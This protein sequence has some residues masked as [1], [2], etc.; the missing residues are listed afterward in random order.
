MINNLQEQRK[1]TKNGV[2][3]LTNRSN[4]SPLQILDEGVLIREKSLIGRLLNYPNEFS[5]IPSCTLL[6]F[7]NRTYRDVFQAVQSVALLGNDFDG[8][9]V[10]KELHITEKNEAKKLCIELLQI[11]F[12]GATSVQIFDKLHQDFIK[13]KAALMTK[14]LLQSIEASHE[15]LETLLTDFSYNFKTLSGSSD[16]FAPFTM[17]FDYVPTEAAEVATFQDET[18]LRKGNILTVIS[19]EGFGKSRLMSTI[20]S[21]RYSDC[22]SFGFNLRL[23]DN[24]LIIHIDTEQERNEVFNSMQRIEKR[25][26]NPQ[27]LKNG[28]KIRNYILQSFVTIPTI[29]EK[30]NWLF[31]TI[32][33]YNTNIGVLILDGLTDFI[34]DVNNLSE[35]QDLLARLN[36]YMSSYNFAIITTIHKNS[37]DDNGKARGHIGS[38]LLRK[39]GAVLQLAKTQN[40]HQFFDDLE[41]EQVRTLTNDFRHGKNRFGSDKLSSYFAWNGKERMF[42]S[43]DISGVAQKTASYQQKMQNT[44]YQTFEVLKSDSAGYSDLLTKYVQISGKAESTAKR[45]ITDATKKEILIKSDNGLYSLKDQT[46]F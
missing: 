29:L 16:V 10:L 3:N 4:T 22:D 38:E 19:G 26:G 32:E 36:S 37:N 18:I 31:N 14:D 35:S 24:E 33:K 7:T 11:P 27:N 17:T 23:P 13:R 25:T 34:S 44:F 12:S 21:S 15:K 42:T 20:I 46:P 28:S 2:E 9:M 43:C 40:T 45:H 41:H 8:S 39:S 5:K 6:H 30:R 1:D